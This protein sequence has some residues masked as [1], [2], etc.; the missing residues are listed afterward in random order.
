MNDTNTEIWQ[1]LVT[2]II[3]YVNHLY[4][5]S[6]I[7]LLFSQVTTVPFINT[8]NIFKGPCIYSW[9]FG[10]SEESKDEN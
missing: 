2:W 7:C 3:S 8:F 5:L 1:N 6:K 9:Q 10:K 4:R